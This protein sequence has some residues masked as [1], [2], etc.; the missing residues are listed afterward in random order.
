MYL[1]KAK[2]Y[3][4]IAKTYVQEISNTQ[5]IQESFTKLR[6]WWHFG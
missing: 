4:I 3:K 6:N 1:S 2:R 5:Q